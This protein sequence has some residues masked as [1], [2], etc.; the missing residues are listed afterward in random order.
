[1][2]KLSGK[3]QSKLMLSGNGNECEPL[4]GGPAHTSASAATTTIWSDGWRGIGVFR[5]A[6]WGCRRLLDV[7]LP[8]AGIAEVA[9]AVAVPAEPAPRPR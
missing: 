7:F 1:M 8:C 5:A 4:T 9:V 3:G 6:L 2:L